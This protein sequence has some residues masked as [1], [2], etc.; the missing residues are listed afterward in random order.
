[1]APMSMTTAPTEGRNHGWASPNCNILCHK[2]CMG[3]DFAHESRQTLFLGEP[4]PL[5][6]FFKRRPDYESGLLYLF[7]LPLFNGFCAAFFSAHFLKNSLV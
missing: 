4:R 1:M 3:F 5:A 7:F 2:Q 6:E